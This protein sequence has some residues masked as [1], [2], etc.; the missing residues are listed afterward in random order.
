MQT[1]KL[2]KSIQRYVSPAILAYNKREAREKLEFIAKNYP[3]AHAHFDV[4]DGAFVQA[5]CWCKPYHYKDLPLPKSFEVHLMVLHPERHIK[6][7]KKRGATRAIFHWEA[8]EN[9]LS[10]IKEI[11]KAHIEVGI[12]VNPETPLSKLR[13]ILPLVDAILIMG[14]H[15]GFAGQTFISSVKKKIKTA[16]ILAPKALLIVDGGVTAKLAPTLIRAGARQLVST[17]AVYGENFQSTH[18]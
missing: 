16:S 2:S 11:R 13:L 1:P 15:P 5:T 14:V 10:V 9:P 7:W 8:T 6:A 18:K 12:A 4:M 17:S 3:S